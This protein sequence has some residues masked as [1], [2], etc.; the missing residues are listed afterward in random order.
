VV[1]TYYYKVWNNRDFRLLPFL[2]SDTCRV[3]YINKD[4]EKSIITSPGDIKDN[5]DKC[6][7]IIPD[8]HV[9]IVHLI[10]DSKYVSAH[11]LFT[12]SNNE[13]IELLSMFKVEGGKICEQWVY[14][15]MEEML[16]QQVLKQNQCD[17]P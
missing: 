11:C 10:S 1:S 2:F 5:I 12:C 8:I 9:E 15:D 6:L 13:Q 3:N 17:C 4:A 16:L 7:L 14:A